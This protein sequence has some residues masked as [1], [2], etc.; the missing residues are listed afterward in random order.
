VRQS[1]LDDVALRTQLT[2]ENNAFNCQLY[3]KDPSAPWSVNSVI[4]VEMF[5]DQPQLLGIFDTRS[6]LGAAIIPNPIPFYTQT[7]MRITADA[8][9]GGRASGQGCQLWPIAL[10]TSTLVG[11]N[12]GDD[13]G[14]IINGSGPG[15]FG[16]LRWPSNS[17]AANEGYLVQELGDPDLSVSD[18]EDAREAGDTAINA[19]DSVWGNVSLSDS[20]AA[21]TVMNN[22]AS[23]PQIRV[24]VWDTAEGSGA[25]GSYHVVGFAVVQVTGYQLSGQ[26]RISALF[27]RWDND[28]CPGNGH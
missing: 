13:L 25:S 18:F 20:A 27:L 24:P 5:Y 11:R 2:D 12:P 1:R 6:A 3:R 28:A 7:T 14:D 16:W 17:G 10:H 9:T 15:N 23:T 22:L 26:N 8:R 19:N 4:A 21:Q